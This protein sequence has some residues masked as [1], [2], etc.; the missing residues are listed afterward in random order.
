MRLLYLN[1]NYRHMAT[2]NRAMQMAEAMVRRGH[3]VTVMT[4]SREHRY[5]PAWSIVNG[6]NL[7]EM[8]NLGQNNS[9]EGYGPIDNLLRC[10]HALFHRYDIVHMF[11]HKP[12]A[13]FAGFTTGRLRGARPIADW[14]DWWGGPGGINDVP[15]RRVPAVGRFEAYWEIESKRRAEGV[16]TISTVLQQRAIDVGV[17]PERVI[18]IPNGAET[19]LIRCLPIEQARQHCGVPPG[20]RIVGFLGMSQG[21]LEIVM[22]ALQQLPEVW[23]MVVGPTHAGVLNQARQFGL[24]DRLW[25]TGFVPEEDMSWYLGCADV[26]CLPMVDRAANRGRLP[27][28]I[29]YYMAAGRPTVASPIGDIKSIVETH[30]VGLLAEDDGFAEALCTLLT[31]DQL[32]AELGRNARHT[33]ET[34]FSW[35][36]LAER[37]EAFY[38]Y[39]LALSRH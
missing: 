27:G 31:R 33:A 12:N 1:H 17:P 14:A 28:K 10:G 2:F 9:G 26:M 30:R 6:V 38:Q 32:R 20:R 25:Q 24:E 22:N 5:R 11:D 3:Q 35:S 19:N 4:V 8:P 37:L 15:R 29:M 16:V 13:S 23:L 18:C 7:G 36:R 34:E 39:V 21:D